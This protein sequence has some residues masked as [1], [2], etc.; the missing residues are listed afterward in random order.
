M[1]LLMRQIKVQAWEWP[2]QIDGPRQHAVAEEMK[3]AG[4][5][6]RLY[7]GAVM[8][9]EQLAESG[10][11]WGWAFAAVGE[12]RRRLRP[13]EWVVRMPWGEPIVLTPHQIAMWVEQ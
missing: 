5:Q 11:N 9:L 3:Q 12:A 10:A 7:D 13:G 4:V 6:V 2:Q 8:Q 1:N